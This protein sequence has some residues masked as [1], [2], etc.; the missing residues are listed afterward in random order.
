VSNIIGMLERPYGVGYKVY[1]D[2][3]ATS[4]GTATVET[5]FSTIKSVQVTPIGTTAI[6]VSV[7]VSG[8]TVTIHTYDTAG[9]AVDATVYVTVI[10]Y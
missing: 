9:A 6:I 2:T 4:G 5:G 3:V 10:G 7:E 8:G 1:T